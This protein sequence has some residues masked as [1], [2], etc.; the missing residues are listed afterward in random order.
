MSARSQVARK[1]PSVLYPVDRRSLSWAAI[2]CDTSMSSLSVCGIGYDG[3]LDKMIGPDHATIR[4][5]PTD[6]YFKRL[7][8]AHNAQRMLLDLLPGFWQ[9]D[10]DR[11]WIAI[12]EP[13]YYGAVKA[14]ASSY[15]KQQAEVAGAF[16]GALVNYGY[17]N[18]VEINNGQWHAT[19]RKDGVEF[20][21]APK[22]ATASEKAKV[23]L[24]NKFRV[25]EW[26][27]A[28]FLLPDLPDL[29]LGPDNQKIPRPESGKG[30][31]AQAVQPEDLYDAAAVCAWQQDNLPAGVAA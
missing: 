9:I 27:M 23:K 13:W 15:L 19:L 10:I 4:W 7:K 17:P 29:V 8:D 2:G 28:A 24:R 14:G 30:A 16:K 1:H 12:E 31:N 11:V 22:G 6:H 3:V 20:E 18:I 26:A 5:T 25:K 21:K